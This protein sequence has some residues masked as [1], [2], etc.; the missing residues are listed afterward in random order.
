MFSHCVV[1]HIDTGWSRNMHFSS[2]LEGS[3]EVKFPIIW[4]DGK[5]EVGRVR[6]EKNTFHQRR[7]RVRRKKITVHEKVE[8]SRNTV[9]FQWFGALEGRKVGSLKQWVRSLL[10]RWE[11]NHCTPL[12]REAHFV[13]ETCKTH[14][15]RSTFGRWDVEKAHAVVARSTFRSKNA[16]NTS[17]PEHFWKMRCWKNAHRSGAKHISKWKRTKHT[18][19]KST[20]WKLSYRKSA[21]RCGAKHISDS[22]C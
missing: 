21:R 1:K 16:Q 9:F 5:A 10:V 3:L 4:T 18:S 19:A 22:K 7:E 15:R 20:F 17:T 8:K 12:W 6:E 11:M 2:F 13:V 14:Q